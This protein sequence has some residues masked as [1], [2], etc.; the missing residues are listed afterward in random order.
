MGNDKETLSSWIDNVLNKKIEIANNHCICPFSNQRDFN[1]KHANSERELSEV[2]IHFSDNDFHVT[3]IICEF[4][5]TVDKGLELCNQFNTLNENYIFL[6]DHPEK[7]TYFQNIKSNN[8]LEKIIVFIQDKKSLLNARNN[9]LKTDYYSYL[10][11]NY[12]KHLLTIG[13]KI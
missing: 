11:E 7:E 13:N 1:I 6:L 9:L 4:Y 2:C 10:E 3:L 5:I 12:K 8:P